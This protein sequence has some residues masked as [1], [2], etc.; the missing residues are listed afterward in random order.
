MSAHAGIVIVGGGQA[1][2]W[3]AK[4]L[5]TEGYAKRITLIADEA[6]LPYERPPLS[7][8]VLLG[9]ADAQ[10][11]F[12]FPPQA[13]AELGV[14]CL[15]PERASAIDRRRKMVDCASG[16]RV[17]YDKLFLATGSSVRR[18]PL[19][20]DP[21]IRYL[22]TLDDA[23]ALRAR[24]LAATRVVIVGGGW[25]GLEVAAT[26]RTLGLDVTLVEA[27]P[28]LCQRAVPADVSTYLLELHR[29]NGV[30]VR[31]AQ[32]IA[33]IE[34]ADDALSV[35]LADAAPIATDLVVIGI[36]IA[37]NAQLAQTAGLDIANGIVVD[38]QGR[39]SDPDIFAAGD[40]AT[41]PCAFL[42]GRPVRLESWANAQNQAIV[43]A[44]A[45]LGSAETY[46]EIPWFWSDQYTANVQML[47]FPVDGRSN[48]TRAV[49]DGG[50]LRLY[51]DDARIVGVVGVN[52]GREIK[53]A[54]RWLQQARAIDLHQFAEGHV[55]LA[56]L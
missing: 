56:K 36:G 35:V 27:M 9:K 37:P 43:A 7:K 3:A 22:R 6:H 29:A 21:R 10:S 8:A 13:F 16:R 40:V 1:G 54:K 32:S 18:L 14:D 53:L 15:Q 46:R 11:T 41:H 20:D 33:R 47:G 23:Q 12:L 51:V 24:L 31:L 44:K 38:H 25:I 30:D 49:G 4:T 2:G 28:R 45:M 42:A 26:A 50:F 39:S 48:H 55:P 52:A 34:T 5:R 19:P 17:P